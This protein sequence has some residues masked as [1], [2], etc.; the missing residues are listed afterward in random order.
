MCVN[1][2]EDYNL[3]FPC[4]GNCDDVDYSSTC[5]PVDNED[6]DNDGDGDIDEG[7][8]NGNDNNEEN[9]NETTNDS[10]NKTNT[11]IDDDNDGIDEQDDEDIDDSDSTLTYC[12]D[13][14]I[15][16]PND[17]GFNEEC[18]SDFACSSGKCIDCSCVDYLDDNI[19]DSED[20]ECLAGDECVGGDCGW[21]KYCDYG[22]CFWFWNSFEEKYGCVPELYEVGVCGDGV[23]DLVEQCE[24]GFNS[25]NSGLNP[26]CKSDKYFLTCSEDCSCVEIPM[27][28]EE[29][30]EKTYDIGSYSSVVDVS[31]TA[32]GDYG[33]ITMNSNSKMVISSDKNKCGEIILDSNFKFRMVYPEITNNIKEN[34]NNYFGRFIVTD[35]NGKNID[36]MKFILQPI[37]ANEGKYVNGEVKFKIE[38]LDNLHKQW[39]LKLEGGFEQVYTRG[40]F[41]KDGTRKITYG[42]VGTFDRNEIKTFIKG[43][44]EMIK[45]EYG[46]GFTHGKDSDSN[47]N[48]EMFKGVKKQSDGKKNNVMLIKTLENGKTIKI[49]FKQWLEHNAYSETEFKYPEIEIDELLD[50]CDR[51]QQ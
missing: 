7:C 47:P 8:D 19:N 20:E 45:F 11:D 49:N 43:F 31:K 17:D 3:A 26:L 21:F 6:N 48:I 39:K 32:F 33:G 36:I 18:E 5:F 28:G 34:P 9:L 40:L 23:V 4:Y 24:P 29:L 37:I 44:E 2:I 16:N 30:E 38:Y 46:V 10:N 35:V 51:V 14:I 13:G 25:L 12:G 1:Y 41:R 15:Q 50:Y 22:E 27:V 42:V